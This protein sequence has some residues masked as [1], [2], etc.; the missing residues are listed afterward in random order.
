MT[1]T[2]TVDL[3]VCTDCLMLLANGEGPE[4][5]AEKMAEHL[6]DDLRNTVPGGDELGFSHWPCE[7]CGSPLHGDRFTATILIMG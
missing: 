4:G 2:D 3:S 6:G 5:H 7:G 1:V